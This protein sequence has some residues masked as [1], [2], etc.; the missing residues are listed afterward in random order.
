MWWWFY[1]K[2]L[3][4]IHINL[5]NDWWLQPWAV[6]SHTF[7]GVTWY[8]ATEINSVQL[9]DSF[10]IV[11]LESISLHLLSVLLE[12]WFVVN[13][14]VVNV[15][16]VKWS[17]LTCGIKANCGLS[18]YSSF[19]CKEN[20]HKYVATD[21]RLVKIS[22]IF[23]TQNSI[24]NR[25]YLFSQNRSSNYIKITWRIMTLFINLLS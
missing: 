4:E 14:L 24:F 8:C 9:H 20:V 6:C 11:P 7:I 17:F 18:Y 22:L 15:H 25:D 19:W 16:A 3:S 23:I 5:A 21:A 13:L 10:V 1:V 2:H 12:W